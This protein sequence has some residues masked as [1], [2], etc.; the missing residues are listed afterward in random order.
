MRYDFKKWN[1]GEK[2]KV[3]KTMRNLALVLDV[4]VAQIAMTRTANSFSIV[5]T[6]MIKIR[7][8]FSEWKQRNIIC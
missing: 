3:K 1:L 7:E 5:Y 4:K 6:Y 2:L 8:K